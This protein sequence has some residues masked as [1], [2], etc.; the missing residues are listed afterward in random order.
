MV[1]AIRQTKQTPKSDPTR[2]YI[3]G[4]SLVSGFA[5]RVLPSTSDDVLRDI[6]YNTYDRMMNDP[7]VAGSVFLLIDSVLADDIRL[8]P[9]IAGADGTPDKDADEVKQACERAMSHLQRPL[10]QTLAMMLKA[11]LKHGYSIA[12]QTYKDGSGEDAGQYVFKSVKVKTR[13]MVSFVVDAQMNVHGFA[14]IKVTDKGFSTTPFSTLGKPEELIEREKCLVLTLN[15]EDEDP[16]G[17]SSL[18]PSYNAWNLKNLVWPEFLLWLMNCAVPGLILFLAENQGDEP[19]RDENGNIVGDGNGNP[20]MVN[21]AQAGVN[22]LQRFRNAFAAAFPFGAK[23]EQIES[24][25]EGGAF[26][27]SIELLNT[28]ITEGIL[29]QASATNE[30]KYGTRSE[31]DQK[32]TVMDLLVFWIKGVVEDMLYWTCSSRL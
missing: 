13:K 18:R 20:N 29:F 30:R 31:S 22:A 7:K 1:A 8:S 5:P 21:A 14:A 12:E 26:K 6:G 25:S 15:A 10:R 32:M 28:E 24:K 17:K 11:A 23:V 9:A 2:E 27:N 3:A 4:P 16:R 19:E